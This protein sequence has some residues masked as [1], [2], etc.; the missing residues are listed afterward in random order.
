MSDTPQSFKNHA[1]FVPLFHGFVFPVSALNAVWLIQRAFRFPSWDTAIA[2]L[3]GVALVVAMFY[4]RIFALTVQDRVIRLEMRLRLRELLPADLQPR[5]HELT[6]GQ[7]VA[8]RF[9]GDR[10]L[11][12]LARRILDE[13]LQDKKAIKRLIQEW[14]ADH[15]RA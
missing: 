13:R 7:L 11:P 8:L 12:A 14:Q 10:E 15:L 4:M 3:M 9:A 6:R 2:A 5:I 1:K